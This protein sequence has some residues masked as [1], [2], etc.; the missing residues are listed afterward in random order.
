MELQTL[1]GMVY[2]P[3]TRTW[4]LSSDTAVNYIASWQHHAERTDI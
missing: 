3:L 4:R 2:S 1:A